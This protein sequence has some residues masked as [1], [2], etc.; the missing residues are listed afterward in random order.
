MEIMKQDLK[1]ILTDTRAATKEFTNQRKYPLVSV[2][3]FFSR[4]SRGT[5]RCS[6]KHV[7]RAGAV[8]GSCSSIAGDRGARTRDSGVELGNSLLADQVSVANPVLS[9]LGSGLWS[10]M[11]PESLSALTDREHIGFICPSRVRGR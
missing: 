7:R 8:G 3:F 4:K 1:K 5:K 9:A 2:I 11:V 6:S 10:A